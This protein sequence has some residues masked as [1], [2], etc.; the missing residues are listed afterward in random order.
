MVNKID[1]P[2]VKS[3]RSS[4]GLSIRKVVLLLFA[5]FFIYLILP[6]IGEFH[7]SFN[8]V[9]HAKVG[10]VVGAVVLSLL[11]YQFTVSTYLL[12]A[13]KKLYY[14]RTLLVQ[15]ASSFAN[16]LIPAGV[17]AIGINY[18]YLRK[19]D[20]SVSEASAVV[21]V[22]NTLG[23]VGHLILLGLVFNFVPLKDIKLHVS[24]PHIATPIYWIIAGAIL[25]AIGVSALWAKKAGRNFDL[26]LINLFKNIAAYR[27]HPLRLLGAVVCMMA[28]TS[29]SVLCL[30]LCA[31]SLGFNISFISSLIILTFGIIG[32]AVVPTPGGLGGAEAGLFAGLLAYG[33][34]R[35][36]ALA[37]A[38]SYRFITYWFAL[39]YGLAA[40]VVAERAGYL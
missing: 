13:K 24:L 11:T 29:M 17:G 10:W 26:K 4:I 21:A 9:R 5:L 28:S 12:I 8:I 30:L 23:I 39:V 18:R 1:K 36:E 15:L 37:V 16:R 25:V 3:A 19:N 35:P 40:M 34:D 20:H 22:N 27:G 6:Q 38:L 31:H 2:K 33:A 32:G 14:F 7:V